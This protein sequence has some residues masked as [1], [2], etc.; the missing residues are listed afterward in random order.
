MLR[1]VMTLFEKTLIFVGHCYRIYPFF[2][3]YMYIYYLPSHLLRS[4]CQEFQILTLHGRHRCCQ[5]K[6]SVSSLNVLHLNMFILSLI[7]GA[8]HWEKNLI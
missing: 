2:M 7:N 1:F 4:M 6:L 8:F 5:C 3:M